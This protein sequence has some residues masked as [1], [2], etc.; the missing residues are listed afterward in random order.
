MISTSLTSES[1]NHLVLLQDTI[2]FKQLP[3]ISGTQ[4]NYLSNHGFF[5][6]IL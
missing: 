2:I 4:F 5:Q 3:I 6:L 1:L